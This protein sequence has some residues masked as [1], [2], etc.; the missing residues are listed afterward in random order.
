MTVRQISIT[1][2]RKH[3]S[4]GKALNQWSRIY[5]YLLGTKGLTR[6][7]IAET[8][9]LRVS[10]V[11]GRTK[12]LLDAHMVRELPRRPCSITQEMAH[13]VIS[14]ANPPTDSEDVIAQLL[15]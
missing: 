5:Q 6:A 4:S 3:V 10:S 14:V 11:C 7:E 15:G 13:P 1:A 2:Y 12:E 9:H 8:L